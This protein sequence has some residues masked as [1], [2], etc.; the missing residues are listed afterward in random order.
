MGRMFCVRI[1]FQITSHYESHK[2][3]NEIKFFYLLE[4][5]T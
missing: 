3:H 5:G 2:I 4:M 1:K